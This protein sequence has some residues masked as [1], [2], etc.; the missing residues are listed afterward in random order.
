MSRQVVII[1]WTLEKDRYTS[2]VRTS[3]IPD[4]CYYFFTLSIT[5]VKEWKEKSEFLVDK[6]KK[7]VKPNIFYSIGRYH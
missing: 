4:H 6:K 7:I 5:D 3:N 1:V 2:H